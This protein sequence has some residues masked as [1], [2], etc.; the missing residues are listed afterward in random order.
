M[1]IVQVEDM[2]D[3]D[4]F[5]STET[6]KQSQ[7]SNVWVYIINSSAVFYTKLHISKHR[8]CFREWDCGRFLSFFKKNLRIWPTR[9]T[10]SNMLHHVGNPEV[11]HWSNYKSAMN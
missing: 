6:D 8:F 11:L 9:N 5:D 7:K 4:M 10:V 3:S 1:Q 2:S